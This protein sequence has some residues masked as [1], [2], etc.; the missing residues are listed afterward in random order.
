MKLESFWTDTVAPFEGR[1]DA[2]PA[3]ADVVV[4]GGGFT[5]LSAARALAQ[6]GAR[7]VVLEAGVVA[8]EASGRNGGHVNNGLAVDYATVAARVGVQQAAAWYRAYDDAVDTVERIVRDEAI[9]CDFQRRGK[10]KL[11]SRPAHYEQLARGFERL[12]READAEVE[13]VPPQRV[14]DEIGSDRFAGGLLF[15][16]SAQM[17]MGRFGRGLAE[18]AAERGALIYD[19]TPV[20]RLQ[21][22]RGQAHR[23]HTRRGTIEADQVLLATGATRIGS[24]SSFSFWR[25]RIVPIGSFIIV[26]EPLEP[27][28]VHAL[29]P[30]RRTYTTTD[31]LHNYFRLTADNRLVFGGRAR[32]ALSSPRSDAKSGHVLREQLMGLFPALKDTRIDYCWGGIVDMTQDR[33]PHAGEKDGL[34]YSMGYSGHG[35]QMSVH[36]GECMARVLAGDAASNPWRNNPWPAIPGHFGPPWFLPAVGLYFH[37][38]NK[39]A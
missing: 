2:L 30:Q 28:M 37:I 12:R 1:S 18:A 33:L 27:A 29:L 7:V 5:G 11:A 20:E 25:R 3:K 6:R 8:A 39:F 34:F 19:H 14:Q 17:H 9:D 15:K 35:T 36:M 21:R 13:L 23:V 38:K 24:F 22:V 10:L 31:T 16:K 4:V 32:F 26:T